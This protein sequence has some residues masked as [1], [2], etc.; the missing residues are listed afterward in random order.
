MIA[1]FTTSVIAHMKYPYAMPAAVRVPRLVPRRRVDAV[2][3]RG[4]RG[5]ARGGHA[6]RPRGRPWSSADAMW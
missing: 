4:T 6:R 5:S 3:P 2:R 1:G